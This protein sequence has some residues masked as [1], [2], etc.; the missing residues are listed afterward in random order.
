MAA[1][2]SLER[3]LPK[4]L[5]QLLIAAVA[6]FAFAWAAIILASTLTLY[7]PSRYL[8]ATLPLVFIIFTVTNLEQALAISSL[9]IR[10]LNAGASN[11]PSYF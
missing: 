5:K 3:I 10:K 6:C 4:A 7:Y 8:R 2:S 9:T 11:R 1:R